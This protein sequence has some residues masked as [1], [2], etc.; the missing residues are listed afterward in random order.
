M[1]GQKDGFGCE[2]YFEI[3]KSFGTSTGKELSLIAGS[4]FILR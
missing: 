1:D 3:G 4:K 2:Y